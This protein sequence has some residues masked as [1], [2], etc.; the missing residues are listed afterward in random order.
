MP[1]GIHRACAVLV[2]AWEVKLL[3]SRDHNLVGKLGHVHVEMMIRSHV[4]MEPSKILGVDVQSW[5]G[6]LGA[7]G[8]EQRHGRGVRLSRTGRIQTW[9]KEREGHAL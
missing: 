3:L 1:R 6:F 9:V 5:E 8:K 7:G 4:R 2:T